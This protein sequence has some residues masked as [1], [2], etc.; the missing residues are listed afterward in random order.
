M[1]KHDVTQDPC[2]PSKKWPIWPVDPWW[3]IDPLPAVSR[4]STNVLLR[5]Q[6]HAGR[7]GRVVRRG[8]SSD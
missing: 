4:L 8:G 1:G 7:S 2:D 3:P 5:A 6:A